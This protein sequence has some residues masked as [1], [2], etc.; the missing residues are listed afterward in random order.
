[1]PIRNASINF[2]I[3]LDVIEHLSRKEGLKML[4]EVERISRG[5]IILTTPRIFVHKGIS[6][7][8]PYQVH[9][10]Y[11]SIKDFKMHKYKVRGFQKIRLIYLFHLS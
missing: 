1:L 10:S 11:W 9:L 6:L 4:K 8:N 5:R 2:I 7:G 3:V